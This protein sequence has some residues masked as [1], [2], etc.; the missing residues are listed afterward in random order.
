[1][2]MHACLH[3]CLSAT[4]GDDGE[5]FYDVELAVYILTALFRDTFGAPKPLP[6]LIPSNFVPKN[7]FQVV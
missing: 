2:R 3:A 7:G 1:M 5:G 4:K 6:I